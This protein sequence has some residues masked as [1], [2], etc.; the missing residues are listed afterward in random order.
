[1]GIRATDLIQSNSI[2]GS[3]FSPIEEQIENQRIDLVVDCIREKYGNHM[4][5][6]GQL[7]NGKIDPMIGGTWGTGSYRPKGGMSK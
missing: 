6:R 4:I 2:Q 3:I 5:L 1:M 7:Y